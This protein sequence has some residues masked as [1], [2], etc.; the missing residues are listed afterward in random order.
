MSKFLTPRNA[1]IF[2]GVAGA[3]VFF[4]PSAKNAKPIETFGTQNI[5]NAYSRGGG[6]H[7]HLPGVA[8]PRGNAEQTASSQINPKGIDTPHFIENVADQKAHDQAGVKKMLNKSVYGQ[9]KGK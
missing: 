2:A 4:L 8:T 6:S 9:E 5:A 1:A 7:T 3:A